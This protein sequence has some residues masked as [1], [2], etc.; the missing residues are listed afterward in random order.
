M[1]CPA[2]VL[3]SPRDAAVPFELGRLAAS[4]IT[5]ARLEPFDSPNHT[6]L[7]GEPAW[8]HVNRLIDEFVNDAEAMAGWPGERDAAVRPALRAVTAPTADS[9][10]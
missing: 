9:R 5:R 7:F 1:R 10:R 8:D 3:H 2:L 6:P 4:T